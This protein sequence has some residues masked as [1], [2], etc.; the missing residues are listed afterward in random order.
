MYR[1][2]IFH[3][4]IPPDPLGYSAVLRLPPTTLRLSLPRVSR[5]IREQKQIFLAP[6]FNCFLPPHL[7]PPERLIDVHAVACSDVTTGPWTI[8]PLAVKHSGKG[9]ISPTPPGEEY[10]CKMDLDVEQK[11]ESWQ[12]CRQ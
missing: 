11:M 7:C 8:G 12:P 2:P 1:G 4:W 10:N 3:P 9:R 6:N 5:L